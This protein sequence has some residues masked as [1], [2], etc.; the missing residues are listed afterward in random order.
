MVDIA[1]T[2]KA[3]VCLLALCLGEP[4]ASHRWITE[5]RQDRI[6]MVNM[7]TGAGTSCQHRNMRRGR[8]TDTERFVNLPAGTHESCS[9]TASACFSES[10]LA[11]QCVLG[12]LASS[13]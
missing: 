6:N 11:T 7:Q 1:L 2:G 8:V 3:N 9:D 13:V 12:R 10:Y 4:V 5:T